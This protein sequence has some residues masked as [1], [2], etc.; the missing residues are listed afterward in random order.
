MA[1]ALAPAS[2]TLVLDAPLPLD[3]GQA[4]GRVEIAYETYGELAAD[5]GNAILIF[6]ALTGDQHVAS[7]HPITGKP[8]WW[9]RMV[10]PG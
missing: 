8:G 5:K 1:T 4:L 7:P 10:G 3:S 9:A 6:H 2:S